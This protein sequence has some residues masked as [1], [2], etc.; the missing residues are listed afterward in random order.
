MPITSALIVC[1][2]EKTDLNWLKKIEASTAG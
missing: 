2:E 1:L